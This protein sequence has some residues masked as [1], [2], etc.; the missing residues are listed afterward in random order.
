MKPRVLRRTQ[1][2]LIKLAMVRI[3]QELIRRGLSTQLILQV[4]DEL[5]FE[6]P[7]DEVAEVSHLTKEHME[8]A[9]EP[10]ITLSV[11]ITVEIG[12]G[13]DWLEAH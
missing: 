6:T 9:F 4:H 11:P 13:R 5:V 7:T 2:D 1:A 12:V 3:S 8:R 10:D